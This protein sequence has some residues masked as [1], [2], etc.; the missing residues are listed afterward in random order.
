MES[1]PQAYFVNLG[2]EIHNLPR[3]F[4]TVF[5]VSIY[6][7]A[8]CVALGALSGVLYG[9]FEAK[10]TGQSPDFYIDLFFPGFVSAIL[11]A[12]LYFVIFNWNLYAANPI[13]VL[14]MRSGGLAIYGGIIGG[15]LAAIVYAKVKKYNFWVLADVAAPAL[16][17]GQAIGRWGNFFN[18]E[19]FGSYTDSL[20]ALRYRAA[21]VFFIPQSVY[22]RMITV[23]G[24]DYIQVQ[25]MF[26]YE[27]SANMVLF[28]LLCFWKR[29]KRFDGEVALFYFFGYG[30][31][32]TFTE[33]F[34]TDQIILWNT[35]I[36][37]SQA[38]AIII[39]FIS[40]LLIIQ[41]RLKLKRKKRKKKY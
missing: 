30:V 1:M 36:P 4:I 37:V 39:I 17:L 18:R 9:Y 27:F 28:A 31:I 40:G 38:L 12:R 41:K 35:D 3:T 11:G 29:R 34:R 33:S 19:A 32:R 13:S 24:V 5:G 8:I 15:T 7:Y 16:L 21:D 22:E 14:N 25:P 2:I 26:L 6:W 23:N 20:F 10:R